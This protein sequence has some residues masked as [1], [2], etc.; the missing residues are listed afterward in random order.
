M[1][2]FRQN[3]WLGTFLIVFGICT[4]IAGYF[5][6]SAK[7]S[8]DEAFSRFN[9]SAAERSRLER[10]DPFPSEANYRKMKVHLENYS[11]VFF[12]AEDGIRDL[13]VTGV[14]TCALPI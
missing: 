11:A 1:N 12:Q 8:S 3:R 4:L 14:Q 9:E 2:W 10:L 5:F 13:T 6:L 7:S